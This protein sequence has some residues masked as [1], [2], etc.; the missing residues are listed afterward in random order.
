MGAID[1]FYELLSMCLLFE[2]V[3]DWDKT[4]RRSLDCSAPQFYK[5]LIISQLFGK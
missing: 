1:L 3:L 5:N 4:Q 2:N